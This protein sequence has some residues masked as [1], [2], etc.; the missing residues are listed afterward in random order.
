VI[1]IGSAS[2]VEKQLDQLETILNTFVVAVLIVLIASA[3]ATKDFEFL[4]AK[5]ETQVA[6][7]IVTAVFDCLFLIFCHIC[8]KIADLIKYCD[9]S[10]VNKALVII[11]AVRGNF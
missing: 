7:P 8:L 1:P 6:Y 2:A 5:L 11:T 3:A 4:G 9:S 10:E